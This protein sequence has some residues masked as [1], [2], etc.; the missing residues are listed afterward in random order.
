MFETF[1]NGL[2]KPFQ[3]TETQKTNKSDPVAS[4]SIAIIAALVLLR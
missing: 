4:Y 3:D 2:K 1:I